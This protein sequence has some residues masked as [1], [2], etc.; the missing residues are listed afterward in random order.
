MWRKH[1]QTDQTRTQKEDTSTIEARTC[2]GGDPQ[3]KGACVLTFPLHVNSNDLEIL[4]GLPTSREPRRDRH[5][6]HKGVRLM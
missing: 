2:R 6:G 3:R 1:N 4:V 5:Q